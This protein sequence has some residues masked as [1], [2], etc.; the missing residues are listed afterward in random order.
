MASPE[1]VRMDKW[2]WAARFFKTRSLAAD[3]CDMNRIAS[4]DH[5][6]KAARDV[7]I[8]DKLRIKNDAGE[9]EI[10]VLAL[11]STN[12]LPR[13]RRQQNSPR[14]GRR[15]AQVARR[16][17]ASRKQTHK[18]RP[19]RHQQ[20]SRKSHPLLAQIPD[21]LYRRSCFSFCH[22]RRESAG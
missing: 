13:N 7:R 6:A 2:L 3:S 17:G 22:S 10:E 11:S 18:E 15:R 9:F 5:P 21:Q 1:N 8:G 20:A 12:P 16:L 14:Q 4:N 19:P